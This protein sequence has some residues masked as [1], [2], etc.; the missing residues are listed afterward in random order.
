MRGNIL[1]GPV[2]TLWAALL[3]QP[4]VTVA[5]DLGDVGVGQDLARRVC[6][7]CHRVQK[8]ETDEKFLDVSAFQTL[9]DNPARTALSLRVF[10]KSPHRDMPD[11]ILSETEI[12]GVIAYIHS[13]K[14][15]NDG[16]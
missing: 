14:K 8:G 15:M 9:A 4:T 5:R 10:L 1:R 2:L 7:T 3:I 16:R 6:A 13:L 11:L 12:D